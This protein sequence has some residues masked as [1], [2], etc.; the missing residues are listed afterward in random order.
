MRDVVI[1]SAARTPIGRHAGALSEVRPD[2]LAAL[3]VK[4]AITRAGVDPNEIE[5][6]YLGCANQAGE[7]NRNVARMAALLAG[8]PHSVAGVTVNRLCA[9]GLNAVNQAARAIACGEGEVFV[10][11]GVESMTRAPYSVPKN[12][13]A[14]GPS[15]NITG[16]D[17]TLGW[18]YPNPKMEAMF[19]LEVMGET[20]ENIYE[21][22]CA[23][24]IEGGPISREEQD[25]FAL[26][27]QRRACV[28]INEGRFQAEIAPIVITRRKGDV[29]VDTD[30]HPRIRKGED[31]YVLDTS[32]EQLA[33]LRPAFRKGGTVTA[34]NSSGLNDGAAALVLMSA[35][36]AEALRMRPLARW[37]ASAAAGV[38]PRTMGL[39]PVPATQKALQRAG[40]ALDDIDLVE[41]NEAFAVQAL[42]V[43]RELG[44]GHEMTN[45]NGGAIALGHP[46]GCSGA[47]I[48]STLI[49][50]MHRRA[51]AGERMRYGLATLCV[52]VGQ[53]E[54]TIVEVMRTEN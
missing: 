13:Q 30:E 14:W 3:V 33:Q 9:S 50:E 53:G 23:G 38:D 7:D 2:D 27:S 15:G 40:L 44:L 19:P 52:G 28:A 35:K 22:S 25:A 46:L 32:L 26:E 31:G 43:M 21:L 17:T 11:G 47:R 5:E 20:A 6:V 49:Y 51:A 41:L 37:L 24:Q 42:A 54:A 16:W 18:R 45:V 4:E 12:P 48:L 39:G 34:G 10:A 29:V 1:V 36:K 8:L